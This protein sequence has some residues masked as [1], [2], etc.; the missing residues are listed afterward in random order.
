MKAF[1][2]I[3]GKDQHSII[4][5]LLADQFHQFFDEHLL[6]MLAFGVQ[7]IELKR[8]F[9]RFFISA[10]FEKREHRVCMSNPPGGVDTR[11]DFKSNVIGGDWIA[12]LRKFE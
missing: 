3:A 7:R 9:R 2:L 1:T 4:R 12:E 11:A 8:E 10:G 5:R 6:D